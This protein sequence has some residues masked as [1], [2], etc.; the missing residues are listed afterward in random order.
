MKD[1]LMIAFNDAITFGVEMEVDLSF[2]T[3]VVIFFEA[4]EGDHIS[5]YHSRSA[6]R[7]DL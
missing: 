1:G 7:W 4:G 2:F 3:Q 5:V 6:T